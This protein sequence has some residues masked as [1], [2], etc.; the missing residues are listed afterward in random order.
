MFKEILHEILFPLLDFLN[1][2]EKLGL[3]LYMG[4]PIGDEIG[5]GPT[6]PS[7]YVMVSQMK[8]EKLSGRLQH[9]TYFVTDLIFN[10]TGALDLEKELSC[11][12]AILSFFQK[13]QQV[14]LQHG[15]IDILYKGEINEVD[16]LRMKDPLAERILLKYSFKYLQ[17]EITKSS[18]SAVIGWS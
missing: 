13:Y 6:D 7:L 11:Y 15:N 4:T 18:Q 12:D 8:E 1:S 17:N 10:I 14:S 9:K 16:V 5:E 3:K 2:N